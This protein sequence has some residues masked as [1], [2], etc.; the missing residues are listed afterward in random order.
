M[1]SITSQKMP[2]CVQARADSLLH[3]FIRLAESHGCVVQ[4]YDVFVARNHF[5][6]RCYE[7]Y[8]GYKEGKASLSTFL[9][10][11]TRYDASRYW[12]SF[13]TDKRKRID[14][15]DSDAQESDVNKIPAPY[16]DFRTLL[17]FRD[18]IK[19]ALSELSAPQVLFVKALVK[20][21]GHVECAAS[22]CGISVASAYRWKEIFK[23][24]LLFF[25]FDEKK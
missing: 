1:S 13:I 16:A 20:F 12:Y 4:Q 6:C 24:K 22:Y 19:A 21:G 8:S 17:M 2:D 10:R 7:L 25:M 11:I 14:A 18:D 9:H 23:K 5:F 15:A 3:A